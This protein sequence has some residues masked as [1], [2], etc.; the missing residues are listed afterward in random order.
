[1]N[2]QDNTE[3]KLLA[4]RTEEQLMA[5]IVNKPFRI[6]EK[7]PNEFELAGMFE[8]GRSTIR[9]A[10]KTLV[11][12]GILEVRRGAGTFVCST[13]TTEEDPLGVSRLGDKYKSAL[14]LAD[15]RHL[16]EPEIAS[17]DAQYATD[18]DV[19]QLVQ[20]CDETE[21]LFLSGRDHTE[22]DTEFHTCI[23]RCSKNRVLENLIPIVNNAIA[24][25]VDL[26]GNRLR[27][28]TIETHRAITNAIASHDAIG[29]RC[30]MIMHLTYSRQEFARQWE[31]NREEKTADD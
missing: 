9:E 17:R 16:I 21:R 1:M 24:T 23:A 22:K 13:N 10:V 12:K 29:A 11:T 30:A 3:K 4:A 14:E 2:H 8:V 15:I 7:L 26:T 25:F 27:T 5:Y 18:Q 6:G 28:E 20:L 31:E 19:R